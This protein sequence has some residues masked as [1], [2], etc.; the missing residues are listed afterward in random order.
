MGRGTSLEPRSPWPSWPEPPRPHESTP[1]REPRDEL[2]RADDVA[3]PRLRRAQVGS[4]DLEV[5]DAFGRVLD[6][7]RVE[8]ATCQD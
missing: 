8:D 3:E 1:P 4:L 2:R 7:E 6:D 5:A